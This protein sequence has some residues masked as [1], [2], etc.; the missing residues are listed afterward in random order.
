MV[1]FL[2]LQ[3]FVHESS[4]NA[5]TSITSIFMNGGLS[6]LATFCALPILMYVNV[7]LNVIWY[8][9]ITLQG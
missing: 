6:V 9:R 8:K 4:I 7:K 3:L 1:T 5:P 2:H